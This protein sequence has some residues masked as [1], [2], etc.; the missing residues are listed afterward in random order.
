MQGC[1]TLKLKI[2]LPAEVFLKEEIEQLT[3]EAENGFFSILPRHVDFVTALVPSI[4]SYITS[5]GEERFIALDEGILVK[6]G[7]QVYISAARAVPGENLEELQDTVENE[8]KQLDE[9]DRKA[10]SVMARLEADTLRRFSR[11]GGEI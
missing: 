5:Q 4:F 2:L 8:M 6:Q 9:S 11:L 10:R 1:L 3:A 7:E